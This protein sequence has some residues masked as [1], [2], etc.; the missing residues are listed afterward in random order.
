MPPSE[1]RRRPEYLDGNAPSLSGMTRIQSGKL[2]EAEELL[3]EVAAWPDDEVE[4][5]PRFYREKAREYRRLVN[6][7][8]G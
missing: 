6:S 2:Y 5:L 3:E 1:P 8:E 4:T 7:G